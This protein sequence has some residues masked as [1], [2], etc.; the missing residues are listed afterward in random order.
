VKAVLVER[1]PAGR[2]GS[3]Q[4]NFHWCP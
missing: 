2:E 3:Y 4:T 1:L